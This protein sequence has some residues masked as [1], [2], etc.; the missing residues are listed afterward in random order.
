MVLLAAKSTGMLQASLEL[1]RAYR[2]P[3][4][5]SSL[6][7]LS[8]TS[9]SSALIVYLH[10]RPR[11]FPFL[12]LPPYPTV[13]CCCCLVFR[14]CYSDIPSSSL[15]LFDRPHSLRQ[16]PLSLLSRPPAR[17]HASSCRD[18]E[19]NSATTIPNL[20]FSTP[21]PSKLHQLT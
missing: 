10:P 16:R 18:D 3:V 4:H 2:P 19:G 6:S 11:F 21:I 20:A 9:P 1:D 5:Q 14:S 8:A 17:Y 12:F 13:Y 15:L 7:H